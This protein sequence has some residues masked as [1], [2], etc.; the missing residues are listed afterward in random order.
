MRAH[1]FPNYGQPKASAFSFRFCGE[2]GS[3]HLGKHFFR[4]P[5]TFVFQGEKP[6]LEGGVVIGLNRKSDA[7]AIWHCVYR[8]VHQIDKNL[9]HLFAIHPQDAWFRSF[10][11]EGHAMT[12]KGRFP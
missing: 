8:V 12:G 6:A 10:Q 2:H 5:V 7:S 11:L 1:D 4:H 9:V 3:E